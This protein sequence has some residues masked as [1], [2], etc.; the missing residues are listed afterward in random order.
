VTIVEPGGFR[1]D[2]G[3]SSMRVDPFREDYEPT[4]GALYAHRGENLDAVRGDPAKAAQAILK[5]AD[6]PNPPRRLLLG[7][8][9]LFLAKVVSSE[10]VAEDDKWSSLSASTDIE[11]L[12]DFE[13]TLLAR[14]LVAVPR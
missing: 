13:D 2:W 5:V 7:T 10:R 9:A 14:E 4:V 3:G 6:M 12:A 11:G 1:T 8:D